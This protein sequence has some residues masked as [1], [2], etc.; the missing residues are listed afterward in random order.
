M[1]QDDRMGAG[2]GA[3]AEGPNDEWQRAPAFQAQSLPPAQ[4]L[5]PPEFA[6]APETQGPA[7]AGVDASG[8]ASVSGATGQTSPP[9]GAWQ[10]AP[11]PQPPAGSWPPQPPA[12]AWPPRPPAGSWPPQ[13][14]AGAW[15]PR[16][17]AGSWPPQVPGYPP[18][19][20]A[21]YPTPPGAS[22]YG[23]Q[24]PAFGQVPGWQPAAGYGWSFAAAAPGPTPGV[25][26]AGIA[27]RFGALIIDAVILLVAFFVAAIVAAAFG[28]P[29]PYTGATPTGYTA[30]LLLYFLFFLVYNPICW[31][32]FAGTLGQRAVGIR[33]VREA[34]GRRL[35][36]GASILRFVVM[37]VCMITVILAIIAAIAADA[38]PAKKAWQDEAS[39]SVV[40]KP[41]G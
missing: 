4:R 8:G 6:D 14:P 16:P 29:D 10:P 40:I 2:A 15:P 41:M 32:R 11:P 22:W 18:P 3:G 33:V 17:P 28:E 35:R 19:Y 31:W 37:F 1:A 7:G 24:A 39:G 23:P 9:A 25:A 12:G 38:D 20:R 34:D 30:V 26:W 21:P 27:L 36:L 5:T 13:P